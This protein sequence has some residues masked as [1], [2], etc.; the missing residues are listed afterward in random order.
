MVVVRQLD[1]L[2]SSSDL[3]KLFKLTKEP[4][5]ELISQNLQKPCYVTLFHFVMSRI[6]V[7]TYHADTVALLIWPVIIGNVLGWIK[8]KCALWSVQVI[9]GVPSFEYNNSVLLKK[10]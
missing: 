1:Y 9:T 6:H 7:F 4:W 10:I 5:S 3:R 2:N 8:V